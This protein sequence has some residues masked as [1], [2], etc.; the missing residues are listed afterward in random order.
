MN[1]WQRLWHV[2]TYEVIKKSE[3]PTRE[4]IRGA[5]VG[6]QY[7]LYLVH[8]CTGCGKIKNTKSEI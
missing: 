7:Y 1:I 5:V 4:T 3:R 2:H 8:R 6:I